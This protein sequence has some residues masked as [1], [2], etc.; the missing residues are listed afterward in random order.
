MARH[1][2]DIPPER[3]NMGYVRFKNRKA[4]YVMLNHRV[5]Y[6]CWMDALKR[7]LIKPGA[8]LLHIDHHADFS[9]SHRAL[10][11]DHEK[12]E[13]DQ[14][15]ELQGFVENKLSVLNYEFIVL[16][17]HR[18][19]IGDAVSIDRECDYGHL[20]GEPKNPLYATTRRMEFFDK[21]GRLHTFYLGGSSV[22]GLA[23][24]YGLL[25]DRWTHQDIQKTLNESAANRNVILDIDLDYFTYNDGEGQWALNE[26]NLDLILNSEGFYYVLG[27]AK[28]ITVA[29]EPFF[30]GNT[31]ECR[32][33]LKK[34]N[35]SMKKYIGAEIEK[36]ALEKFAAGLAEEPSD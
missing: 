13:D 25:T 22:C 8:F 35:E 26:R 6:L 34:V 15:E 32:Y 5:A 17:M 20:F 9:V 33:I 31:T 7:N 29:L 21:K 3:Y 30:C 4:I 36:A 24:H 23:D 28:V 14:T 27:K 19:V 1:P 11:D 2:T 10:I 16:A 12:I 18:G